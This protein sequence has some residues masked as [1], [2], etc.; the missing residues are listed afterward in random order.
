[1]NSFRG[2]RDALAYEIERQTDLLEAGQKIVQETRLW[3]AQKGSTHSMRSKEEAHDYRYFPEPDLVPIELSESFLDE[4]RRSLPELPSVRRTRLEKERGLS[5][6]DAGVITAEKPLADYFEQALAAFEEPLRREA[7][8][9]LANWLTT[10]LLGRLHAAQ[11][12]IEESPIS[13]R[14]LA[15]LVRLVLKGTVSGK[16]AKTV[17][18]DMFAGGGDPETIVEQKGLTQIEDEVLI[19]RWADEAIAGQPKSAQDVKAGKAAAL[20]ALVGAVLKK[21]G[22]R[23]NPQTVQRLLKQKLGAS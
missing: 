15:A 10:E 20:G 14:R 1:M 21:S 23:A 12:G 9:P 3:D 4:L 17:F 16:T 18:D 22:G 2:V 11:K 13:S 19:G 7:A 6:Y 5:G 8:K